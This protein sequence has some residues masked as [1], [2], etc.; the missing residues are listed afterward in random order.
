MS[1]LSARHIKIIICADTSR[2]EGCSPRRHRRLLRRLNGLPDRLG[3]LLDRISHLTTHLSIRSEA[4]TMLLPRIKC[5]A[6][7]W[8]MDRWTLPCRTPRTHGRVTV[9]RHARCEHG[10]LHRR[11]Y[12]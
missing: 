9:R 7:L 6:C 11:S 5:L 1:D 8:R 12:K 10:G 2:E 4:H 3:I